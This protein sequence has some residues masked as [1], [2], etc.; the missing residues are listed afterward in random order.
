MRQSV[1]RGRQGT[2]IMGV[3]GNDILAPAGHL[4]GLFTH[5]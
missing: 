2:G 1:H 5:A 4:R 3:I